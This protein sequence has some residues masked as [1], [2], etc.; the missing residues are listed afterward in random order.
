MYIIL[1]FS[2]AVDCG[3]VQVP[4]N[5]SLLGNYT[6]FP[7][8]LHFL[9]DEGFILRGLSVRSCM[10]NGTWSGHETTCEGM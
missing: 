2:L 4:R 6:T 3:K 5:G 1:T 7:N 9:C 10:A 8:K